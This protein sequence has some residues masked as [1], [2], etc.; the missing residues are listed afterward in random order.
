MSDHTDTTIDDP[1]DATLA[2]LFASAR[3]DSGLEDRLIGSIRATGAMPRRRF[4]WRSHPLTWGVA[5]SIGLGAIGAGL[6]QMDGGLPLPWETDGWR[7]RY[8]HDVDHKT[9][10]L[11]PVRGGFPA[12]RSEDV[13][14]DGEVFFSRDGSPTITNRAGTGVWP[15]LKRDNSV[16]QITTPPTL[17]DWAKTDGKLKKSLEDG[18]AQVDKPQSA[19]AGGVEMFGEGRQGMPGRSDDNGEYRSKLGVGY[20]VPPTGTGTPD[21]ASKRF[22]HYYANPTYKGKES[23]ATSNFNPNLYRWADTGGANGR[24]EFVFNGLNEADKKG[25]SQTPAFGTNGQ[26]D[27]RLDKTVTVAMPVTETKVQVVRATNRYEPGTVFKNTGGTQQAAD[28]APQ[29]NANRKVILR[30]GEVEFEIESFDSAVAAVTKLVVGIEGAFV[31]T[32]NSDKLPNGKVKG[33]VVLRVPPDKLDGLVLDLRKE[34]GKGG[35]LKGQRIGSQDVTKQY[36][37]LESR[38]KAARTMET[39]LLAM[40]KDGKGEIKQLLDAEKELGVWRTKIEEYEGELRYFANLASLSTLTVTLAEKEIKAAAGVTE[41]EVVQTGVE[42]EDVEQAFRDALAAVAAANGRVT[43]SD[44]KQVSSGQFNATLNFEI[45]PDA[46]G[47]V[48]DRLRQLGRVARLEITR[49]TAADAGG[50]VTKDAKIKKGDTQFQVQIYNVANIPPRETVTLRVA[51]PDVPAGYKAVR[52]AV[53]KA[54]GRVFVASLSGG[55]KSNP[56]GQLDFEVKRAEESAVMTAIGAAGETVHR[57]VTRVA[58]GD[59]VTDTKVLVRLQFLIPH[60]LAPRESIG[61]GVEVGDV[62]AAGAVL[63][64]A[65]KDAGGRIAD[66]GTSTDRSTGKVTAKYVFDVP[67]ASAGSIAEKAKGTGTVKVNQVSRNPSAPEG[68]Y[69]TARV[70]VILATPDRIVAPDDGFAPQLKNGLSYSAKAIFISLSWLVVGLLVVVPWA[71]VIYGVYRLIR[72][73]T[74]SSQ[75][76]T[77]PAAV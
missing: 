68:R 55:D 33:A 22:M 34:L 3:P 19:P 73:L 67:L 45:A 47:P 29:A 10:I 44:L 57:D 76:K 4:T 2:E 65:V 17:D 51:T 36:T 24:E 5:A 11:P 27:P 52:D 9:P 30:S 59:A 54:K 16:P 23:G 49:M 64:T 15:V 66:S 43:K 14:A 69:A 60:Q 61:L 70:E 46:A 75:P 41:S 74:R 48:R 72:R 39:R 26:T 12:P 71:V 56:T 50:T 13:P 7:D 21:D 1:F 40:I 25:A 32:V 18:L 63:T 20:A 37:D 35:E 28:P 58:E 42:V 6:S 8:A 77:P 31:S 62:D 53:E 38:L